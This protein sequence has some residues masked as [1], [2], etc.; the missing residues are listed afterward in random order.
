MAVLHSGEAPLFVF[1]S[2]R[3]SPQ[4]LWARDAVADTLQQSNQFKPWLF[5]HAPASSVI[6]AD[7][8]LAKVRESDLVIWLVE[9][10]TT[11]PVRAEITAALEATRRI[12]MFRITSPPSDSAT[13]ALIT[14]VGTKWDYVA[15]SADLKGKLQAALGDEIVRA[16]RAAGQPTKPPILDTLSAQS[17]SRCI[18]RWLAA[19]IPEKIAV[20]L[21]DDP[22]IGLLQVPIFASNQFA[23]LRG[24]IGAG[25][26]LAAERLF[27]DALRRARTSW[28]ENTPIFIEA[29]HM[30]GTLEQAL[31]ESGYKSVSGGS[32][33]V[34]ID[35][36]DDAPENRRV[37]LARA[38]RRLTFECPSNR[39]LVTSRPLSDLSPVFD[40][41]FIDIPPLTREQTFALITRVAGR[42]VDEW[43]FWDLPESFIKAIARP[44]F[45]ILVGVSQRGE[46]LVPA[47]KGRLLSQLVEASL[48]RAD[49]RQESADPLLRKLARL[50]MD[51]GGAPV[52]IS[53]V[54][55]Y[56]EVAPLL[57]SRLIVE[58]KG[59]LMFPLAIL[60]EWFAARELE[61]GTPT[62]DE[63]AANTERLQKWIVPFEM[64]VSEASASNVSRLMRPLASQR[65][66][67]AANILAAAFSEWPHDDPDQ[68]LPHWRQFGEQLRDAMTAWAV[69]MGPLAPLV[70]PV[71]RNGRLRTVGVRL[72]DPSTVV[73]SWARSTAADEVVELPDGFHVDVEWLEF[74]S[75]YRFAVHNGWAWQWALDHLRR[76]VCT[77]LERRALP[78]IEALR[79]EFGWRAALSVAQRSGSL[80]PTPIP[81]NLLEK[82]LR[83]YPS[84]GTYVDSGDSFEV[85]QVHEVLARLMEENGERHLCPPWPGPENLIGPYVW[86]GYSPEAL[87]ARTR[88]VY[89]AALGAY[90]EVVDRWFPRF[91]GDLRLESKRPFRLIG[92]VRPATEPNIWHRGPAICYYREL[93][94]SGPDFTVNLQL[95]DDSAWKTFVE[96]ANDRLEN[97]QIDSFTSSVLDVF[98]LDAAEKLTYSWL[99]DDL[100]QV[101]WVQ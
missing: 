43:T 4:T 3:I 38:A 95:G 70:A 93:N 75:R 69:G 55:T 100:R 90:F 18:D 7:S 87:L 41:L 53:D 88:A 91:C 34:I 86:S 59:S 72:S 77:L 30:P 50:V 25:K 65:P 17:R 45:A 82:R 32:V 94:L 52:P 92:M 20:A 46:A 40:D 99:L 56:A 62:A 31:I 66:A 58:R 79:T 24:E 44:L 80:D 10:E 47:P 48:G 27:Q 37:E 57:R 23:I 39:V 81:K 21:A 1:V 22:S 96:H 42:D 28:K 2:S 83:S 97:R 54:S 67:F 71:H 29:K 16:W 9:R 84:L 49:A 26:S 98:D 85:D 76:E 78:Q 60:A 5:E 61:T 19:G 89:T 74:T 11:E 36:L 35:G 64:C 15:D 63:M 33:L 68:P 12:L 14:C 6:L 73:V 8:Y 13:E 101:H 51:R